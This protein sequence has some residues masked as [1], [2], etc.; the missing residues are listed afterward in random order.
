MDLSSLSTEQLYNVFIHS[1]KLL[2]NKGVLSQAS[3]EL[4]TR[5]TGPFQVND[6]EAL[7]SKSIEADTRMCLGDFADTRDKCFRWRLHILLECASSALRGNSVFLDLGCGSGMIASPLLT[8]FSARM[9]RMNVAY[10]MYDS[11]AGA[12][13]GDESTT[14]FYN[15]QDGAYEMANKIV[16]QYS[17]VATLHSG[18]LP[19]ALIDIDI[20]LLK[21]VYFVSLDLNASKPEID[22]MR[23]LLP[24]LPSGC[25]VIL[26]DFGFPGSRSQYIAHMEF[27][28]NNDIPLLHLP[29]GQGLLIIR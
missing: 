10:H 22:T 13:K 29:T 24:Y 14:T 12:A 11:F 8:K 26:D 25:I 20:D 6:F 19:Q 18:Y 21:R 5:I 17:D 2:R 7:F 9:S 1:A 28:D 27:A 15:P 4:Y 23:Y 3:D 16:S